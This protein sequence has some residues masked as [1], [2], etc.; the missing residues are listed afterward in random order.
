[1]NSVD[2]FFP[3]PTGVTLA[4]ES[5]LSNLDNP[6]LYYT[7]CA[8]VFVIAGIV[9]GYFIWRKGFMQTLDAETEIE[10]TKRELESLR[11][12]VEREE[13]ELNS[14]GAD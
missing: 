6:W 4:A 2:K 9:C 8:L 10:K 13:S 12:D 7:F 1:M 5:P 11:E 14:S 3:H